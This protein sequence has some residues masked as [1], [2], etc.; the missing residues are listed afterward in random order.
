MKL[1][2]PALLLALA[3]CAPQQV[4]AA[5]TAGQPEGDAASTEPATTEVP[6][7]T[8]NQ[9]NETEAVPPPTPRPVDNLQNMVIRSDEAPA[10]EA[11]P[12]TEPEA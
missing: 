7:N 2:A 3:A 11:V 1:A 6:A 9:P 4:P 5:N 12:P 10:N 8:A